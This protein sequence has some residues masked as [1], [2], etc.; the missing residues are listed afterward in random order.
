MASFC[1]RST[2]SRSWRRNCVARLLVELL[3]GEQLEEAAE[4]EDR[5]AQLVR[6]GG[7]EALARRVELGELAAHVVEL[8]G[9]LA[10]LVVGSTRERR[11]EVAGGDG[12]GGAPQPLHAAANQRA[13]DEQPASSA[14]RQ[15][16][17]AR[18]ED[19]VAHQRDVAAT[20]SSGVEKTR[21]RA[22]L[23]RRC[24][25]EGAAPRPAPTR[26]RRPASESV[27]AGRGCGRPGGDRECR[28]PDRDVA[29][30][31]RAA[32]AP[33]APAPAV[34]PSSV[35]RAPGARR[36]RATSRSTTSH[37][38]VGGR[39]ALEL[40]RVAA[41][42]WRQ[43]AAASR[44]AACRQ[45]RDRVEVDDPDR[46]RRRCQTAGASRIAASARRWAAQPSLSRKR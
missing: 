25:R 12:P 38:D 19:P 35:T 28:S 36:R 11:G 7:D 32:A 17:R 15:G 46:E 1:S 21:T 29:R 23:A 20:S 39:R 26:P 10:E 30:R 9:Q 2:W 44:R 45:R 43:R 34:E 37:V 27:T 3:V 24:G 16:D 4:R 40:G 41:A 8:A 6:G 31:V 22:D 42:A 5:R 14:T 33:A 18:H 13:S